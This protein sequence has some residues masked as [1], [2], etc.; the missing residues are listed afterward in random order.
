[1]LGLFVFGE[2]LDDPK[3]KSLIDGPHS[4]YFDLLSLFCYGSFE[5]YEANIAKYPQLCDAQIRKLKQLSII[6]EAHKQKS[7]PYDVLFK[8][9][10]LN[11]CR[12]LEDL[13]IE[14]FYLNVLTGKLDQQKAMLEVES[15]VGRDIHE[16]QVSL[17]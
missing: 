8:K 17:L 14:L 15:A 11:S 4:A 1:M 12:E 13:V 3:I 5:L 7:I 6:D 16:H 9:L 2:F 10:K